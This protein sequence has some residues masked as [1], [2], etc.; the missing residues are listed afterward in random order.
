[1]EGRV[2]SSGGAT[3]RHLRGWLSCVL[4]G[5]NIGGLFANELEGQIRQQFDRGILFCQAELLLLW[6][7]WHSCGHGACMWQLSELPWQ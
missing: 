2:E 1:M 3:Q 5:K 4:E 7:M 6:Q